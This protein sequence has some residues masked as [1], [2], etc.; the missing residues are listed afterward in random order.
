MAIRRGES[1]YEETIAE[2]GEIELRLEQAVADSVLP[3]QPDLGRVDEFILAS[4]R[5]AWGW[6]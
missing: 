5:E 1:T 2:I 4:Y 6:S 3:E